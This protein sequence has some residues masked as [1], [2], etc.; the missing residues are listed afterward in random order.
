MMIMKIRV[1]VKSATQAKLPSK[2]ISIVNK[3]T[4]YHPLILLFLPLMLLSYTL[5]LLFFYSDNENENESK[6][7][8]P[9]A[10]LLLTKPVTVCPLIFTS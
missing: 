5:S 8:V 3:S 9:K 7:P 6:D 10:S 4:D 2:G 1:S